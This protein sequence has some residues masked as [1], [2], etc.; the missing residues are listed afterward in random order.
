MIPCSRFLLAVVTGLACA[1]SARASGQRPSSTTVP[2]P[3]LTV[4]TIDTLWSPTLKERRP[5]LVYTP[6]AYGAPTRVPR[7]YP[8]LYL[9]DGDVHFHSVTGVLQMLSTGVGGTYAIPEMIVIAIPVANRRRDLTPTRVTKDPYGNP[10]PPGW[11]ITG[12]NPNFLQ[13]LKSE[14]IPHVD[15]AY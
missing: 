14:L 10:L 5:Y 15:S 11:D 4:G 7:A 3:A 8:V 1:A 6:P 12:G 9:L 13:F 2:T